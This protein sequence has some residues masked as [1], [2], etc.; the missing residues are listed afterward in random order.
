MADELNNAG[1]NCL[2]NG[3]FEEAQEGQPA[4]W[5]PHKWHGEGEFGYV[6][7]GRAGGHCIAIESEKGAD[8]SWETFAGA[9][10]FSMYRLSGWV[11]TDDVVATTGKG[12]LINIHGMDVKTEPLT[13]THDW[14]RLEVVF[15]TGEEDTLHV[16]CLFGGWGS[17]TGRAWYDDLALELLSSKELNPAITIDA[18]KTGPPISKYIYGQ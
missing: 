17:A 14:T 13:G 2:A 10:P 9:K 7:E 6:E 11:K 1:Q 16:N 12:A 15:E 5:K 3:S 18:S 8:F 4:A